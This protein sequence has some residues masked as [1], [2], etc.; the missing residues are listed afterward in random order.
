MDPGANMSLVE[1][2][3]Q[4]NN[5]ESDG[6]PLGETDL[7]IHWIIRLRDLL[8]FRYRRERG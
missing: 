7:H 5:P 2:T 6:E 3:Q 4:I 8:K 1:A